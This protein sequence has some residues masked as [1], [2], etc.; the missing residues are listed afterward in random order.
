MVQVL[1]FTLKEKPV[2]KKFL[3]NFEEIKS[4]TVF[5][6]LRCKKDDC[7]ITLYNSGKIVIQ[8]K[9]EKNEI[10][11]KNLLLE[12]LKFNSVLELG[13]DEVGRS[14]ITGPFVISGVLGR[15]DNL[16]ELR[17]S[18]KTS[19]IQEKFEIVS[20]NSLSQSIVSFNPELI[21]FLRKKGLTLNEIEVLTLNNISQLYLDLLGKLEIKADGS[22][23]N[24]SRK[25]IDFLVGGDDKDCVISGASITAKFFRDKSKNNFK[26][27]TW[28]TK[29]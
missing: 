15:Q 10:A 17:D 8:G 18:K 5:E 14:E 22:K 13:F 7:I 23:L 20:K 1:N 28:K 6:E 2:A 9:T 29:K 3:K 26:R 16:R 19:K 24:N 11:I 4:G 27:K 12:K 21:D 25:E